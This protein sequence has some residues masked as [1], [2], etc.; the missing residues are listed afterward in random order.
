[1]IKITLQLNTRWQD[2]ISHFSN[3]FSPDACSW[4]ICI[5]LEQNCFIFAL[6]QKGVILTTFLSSVSQ[7]ESE[8]K[9]GEGPWQRTS[10]CRGFEEE[11]SFKPHM[12]LP[13]WTFCQDATIVAHFATQIRAR[14]NWIKSLLT[15]K[16]NICVF[17]EG[18]ELCNKQ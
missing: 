18:V 1:M 8:H 15:D 14:G 11:G 9:A 7:N 2:V 17:E 5:Y 16:V 12:E 10:L 13:S 6:S 3:C 4:L